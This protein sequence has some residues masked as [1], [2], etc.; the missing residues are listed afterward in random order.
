MRT[1]NTK[2]KSM[3]ANKKLVVIVIVSIVVLVGLPV[4][5]I[6][7]SRMN[8]FFGQAAGSAVVEAESGTRAGT[9]T[10]VAD[11]SASGGRYIRIGVIATPTAAPVSN[12]N[13]L[14]FFGAQ[15]NDIDRVKIPLT[16]NRTIDVANSF[17]LE[18]WMKTG[19]GNTGGTCTSGAAGVGDYDWITG[20]VLFDRD[21]DA[22]GDYGKYGIS[23]I[24][25]EG[26]RI[27]YGVAVGAS[28]SNICSTAT[29]ANGAWHHVAATR[30]G[31]T[32]QI[33]LFVNGAANGCK[34]GPAGDISYRDA[35]T[36]GMPNDSY[37]VI[38]AEKHDY[39]SPDTGFRGWIDEVRISNT[40]RY[41]AA[42]TRPTAPFQ[43]DANTVALYHM[44]A[45]AG[46]T[47]EDTTGGNNGVLRVGGTSN[48]P[49][50]ST[51]KP[52]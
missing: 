34:N 23:L 43:A 7:S 49:Q 17:T 48:G 41:T 9:I 14:R 37:F 19:T 3:N 5:V 52:F 2:H 33:C 30:N 12:T 10:E 31:T 44:D 21:I 51:D 22:A 35:R 1:K 40:V 46:T 11:A 45:S 36:A 16:L 25:S 20:N 4:L 42:F 24:P 15:D 8:N 47:V 28:K 13:S 18:W 50:W 29:V 38:G 27:S 6:L 39:A 26:G 32:G